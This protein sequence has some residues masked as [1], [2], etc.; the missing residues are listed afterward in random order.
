[1]P[2]EKK[3]IVNTIK[4]QVYQIL[5]DKIC[6]GYFTPNQ[7]LRENELAESLQVSRSPIREA[8]HQLANDGLVIE[9]SNKGVFVREF[10]SKDIEE[11]FELRN[12]IES[13]AI[14][15]SPKNL[16]VNLKKSLQNCLD[17]LIKSHDEN[18]LKEYIEYDVQLHKLIISLSGNSHIES[19]YYKI[20]SMIQPFRIYSLISYQRFNE[21]ILEHQ[22]I[23]QHILNGTIE[24]AEEV[25]HTHLILAKDKIIEYINTPNYLNGHNS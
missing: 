20:H 9:M 10:T 21:S 8:F 14:H 7:P 22:Q 25:N 3:A 13:Y 1:M 12:L 19:T 24:K 2:A 6:E 15:K 4:N 16:S 23:V 11:I 18:N 17:N 5:K